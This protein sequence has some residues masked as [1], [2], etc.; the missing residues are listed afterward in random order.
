MI[1]TDANK[2]KRG[3]ISISVDGEFIFA[4]E[5]DAWR[6]TKLTIG[7]DVSEE[8]LNSLLKSSHEKE[9]KRRALNMLSARNYTAKNLTRRLTEK[10]DAQAAQAAV[11]R[12]QELGLIN[13]EDYACRY[14]QELFEI[15]GYAPRRI[16]Y[17]LQKR[18]ISSE[19]CSI[20]IEQLDCNDLVERAVQLL[21]ARF[22]ILKKESDIRKASSLLE[23]YGYSFSDIRSALREISELDFQE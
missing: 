5:A 9:A 23:R 2:T 14:A 7:D 20:S 15:R 18:G 8:Q 16:R 4:V 13:D 19:L 10:T 22:G 17:E 3:R 21:T 1:I 12:M 11:E 6:I